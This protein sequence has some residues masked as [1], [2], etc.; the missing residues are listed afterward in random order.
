MKQKYRNIIIKIRRMAFI[1]MG[2]GFIAL[3]WMYWPVSRQTFSL[4][5]SEYNRTLQ[6]EALDNPPKILQPV[7]L[8]WDLVTQMH[9]GQVGPIHLRLAIPKSPSIS[10]EDIFKNYRVFLVSRINTD[11]YSI[12]PRG[13]L[14][15]EI[16]P[17]TPIDLVW[18]FQPAA[19]ASYHGTAWVYFRFAPKDGGKVLDQPVISRAF[20]IHVSQLIK[21]N[22]E[23]TRWTGFGL[24]A[25]GCLGVIIF[26]KLIK[27]K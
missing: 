7:N 5:V 8:T 10:G 25:I 15:A 19:S 27:G 23:I 1:A 24:F 2:I 9:A 3:V 18:S 6:Q 17:G 20:S 4:D 11:E 26:H 16:H 13:E 14:T 22:P 21:I 12:S